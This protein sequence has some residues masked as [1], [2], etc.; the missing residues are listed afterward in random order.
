MRIEL[1]ENTQFYSKEVILDGFSFDFKSMN[2]IYNALRNDDCDFII[3]IERMLKE[4]YK[5]YITTRKDSIF[6]YDYIKKHFF[7]ECLFLL[8]KNGN[9]NETEKVVEEDEFFGV[10]TY[11]IF[12]KKGE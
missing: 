10:T 9:M 7:D 5:I 3:D 1:I 4:K 2:R 6:E 11:I 12:E 8:N